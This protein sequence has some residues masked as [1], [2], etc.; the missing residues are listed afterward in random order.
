MSEARPRPVNLVEPLRKIETDDS[1]KLFNQVI[2]FQFIVDPCRPVSVQLLLDRISKV[3]LS[4]SRP[5]GYVHFSRDLDLLNL[6]E[7]AVSCAC[8][9]LMQMNRGPVSDME[10]ERSV[11]SALRLIR[12]DAVYAIKHCLDLIESKRKEMIK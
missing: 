9:M 2:K 3:R 11:D 5:L 7:Q 6:A 10:V 12:G 1:L 8:V 4:D